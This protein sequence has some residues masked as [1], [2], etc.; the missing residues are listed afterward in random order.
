M[1]ESGYAFTKDNID[2]YLKELSKEYRK[3]AE[4]NVPAELTLIGGAAILVNYGFRNATTD[5]DALIN[6][7]SAMKEAINCIGD[8]FGLPNG[9]LNA[10]F[11]NT[12]SFS[13]SNLFNKEAIETDFALWSSAEMSTIAETME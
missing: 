8:R 3:Q 6:A 5:I 10:D 9:W 11:K 4:K 12:D 7:S 2:Q 1:S 13:K